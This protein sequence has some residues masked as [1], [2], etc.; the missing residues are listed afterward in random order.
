MAS[1]L[2]QVTRGISV[3]QVELAYRAGVFPMADMDRG[4]VTWHRPRRRAI[5]PLDALHV[6]GSLQRRMRRGGFEVTADRDFEGVMRACADR[7][8]TWISEEFIEIYG[9][10]HRQGKA[11]S[12]EVWVDGQLAGGTYGVH[13]G[14]AFFAESKFHRV[15]DMSKVA[16]VSLARRLR[17][18][19]FELLEV[20]YLTEHLSHF[21]TIEIGRGDY[22]EILTR[23]LSKDAAF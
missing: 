18:R 11:H 10:L 14:A 21:G 5:I 12:I 3:E 9:E 20:Q 16:V 8:E 17:E 22:A 23:A 1:D 7:D 6:S 4:L 2:V 15:T 19:G 13:L